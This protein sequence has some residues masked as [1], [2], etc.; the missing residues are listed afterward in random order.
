MQVTKVEGQKNNLL[1][2]K[3]FVQLDQV[4]QGLN[5]LKIKSV[6]LT[7]T[8]ACEK[9]KRGNLENKKQLIPRNCY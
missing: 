2:K 1:C 4:D 7:R 5:Q 8:F 6:C 9:T 3:Y